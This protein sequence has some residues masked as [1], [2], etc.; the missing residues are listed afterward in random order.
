MH[1]VGQAFPQVCLKAVDNENWIKP[2]PS[3]EEANIAGEFNVWAN[4]KIS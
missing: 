2:L 1:T 4:N 3:V